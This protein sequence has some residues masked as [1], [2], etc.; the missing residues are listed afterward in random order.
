MT[1][2]GRDRFVAVFYHR[3]D[4]PMR[5]GTQ[6]LGYSIFDGL[7]GA[8]VACGDVSALSPGAS[9]TWAGFNEKC[10][11]SIM[12][13]VGMFSMLARYPSSSNS[14]NGNWMPMLDTVGLRKSASDTYWPVSIH[15]GKLVCVP[16][17]G[18]REHPDA[19]RRPVPTTLSLRIPLA[20]SLTAKRYEKCREGILPTLFLVKCA[21]VQNIRQHPLT[22]CSLPSFS[23]PF[24]ECSV[25]AIFALNQEKVVDDYLVSQGETNE[26]EIEEKYFDNCRR[27]VSVYISMVGP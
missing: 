11:L 6:L 24:E 9:L 7:T 22:C 10:A 8:T 16:L 25:R 3:S 17:R 5:D 21:V 23:G 26:E 15:G 2:V 13:S 12:D 19:A 20:T 1:V 18:G 4:A 14:N 27:V